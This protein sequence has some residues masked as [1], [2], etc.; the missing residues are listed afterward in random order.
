M[1]HI[2][3]LISLGLLTMVGAITEVVFPGLPQQWIQINGLLTILFAMSFV[4]LTL[5]I[6]ASGFRKT[7]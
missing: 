7:D 2:I 6:Q 1:K 4:I 3:I 5:R